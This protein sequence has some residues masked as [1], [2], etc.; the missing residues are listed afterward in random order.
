MTA[1]QTVDDTKA[2]PYCAEVI[3]AAAIKCRYCQS[4]LSQALPR[5]GEG[6]QLSWDRYEK[7][8]TGALVA[9]GVLTNTSD[10]AEDYYFAL[11]ALTADGREMAW[12]EATVDG[13][14]PGATVEVRGSLRVSEAHGG[15]APKTV[16]AERRPSRPAPRAHDVG[17]PGHRRLAFDA[18][19]AGPPTTNAFAIGSLIA[20]LAGGSIIAIV[21]GHI[22][23]SQIRQ[24][25][26]RQSGEGMATAGLILGYVDVVIFVIVFA[27][28]F[29]PVAG[30]FA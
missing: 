9:F 28:M 8:P 14:A 24:S 7:Y 22:A 15:E 30:G 6:Y 12:G 25:R 2:C 13:V 5:A 11:T 20:G 3:K 17:L 21:L 27:V 16:R 26:G 10:R 19:P 4:D 18:A 23:M 29:M 1:E